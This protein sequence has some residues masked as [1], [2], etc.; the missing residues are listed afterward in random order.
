MPYI[1]PD[2]LPSVWNCRRLLI[3]DDTRMLA[4]IL[5]QLLELTEPENWEETTGITVAETVTFWQDTFDAFSM[6]DFCMIGA[7]VAILNDTIPDSMLLC[8]G[9]NFAKID[10]PVLY[11]V[12]PAVLIVDTDTGKTPDLRE[13]FVIASGTTI[14]DHDTGG[15]VEHQLTESEM[16]SHR[17]VYDKE[18]Y[19]ID[20]ESIGIPDPT[21]VGI[22]PLPTFTSS[23]GGDD[24]HN[25]M[26]PYYA[27][28]YAVVAR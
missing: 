11:A 28:K 18:I 1:T 23:K 25:N 3:P 26:P 22:P 10:Y 12:L 7:I 4:A 2:T 14:S 16:P 21:G 19:N 17:H 5:G 13:V 20:V 8:D 15:E 9:S 27:L 6:G 24:S